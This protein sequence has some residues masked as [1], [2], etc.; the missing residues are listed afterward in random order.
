MGGAGEFR[1]YRVRMGVDRRPITANEQAFEREVLL[2]SRP[3]LVSFTSRTC[4]ACA[5]LEPEFERAASMDYSGTKFVRVVLQDS[6]SLF[7]RYRITATP[8]LILFRGGV[9]IGRQLGVMRAE[10]LLSWITQQ[11]VRAAA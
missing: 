10:Q 6:L 2:H 1:V 8:T 7:D 9:E 4:P 5:A 3:V 11:T